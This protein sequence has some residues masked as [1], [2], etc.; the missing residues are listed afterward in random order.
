[1]GAR[2]LVW[3]PLAGR[4]WLVRAIKKCQIWARPQVASPGRALATGA[5]LPGSAPPILV[6]CARLGIGAPVGAPMP[7]PLYWNARGQTFANGAPK[8]SQRIVL[9][10][11]GPPQQ[12]AD[13]LLRGPKG[14]PKTRGSGGNGARRSAKFAAARAPTG[15]WAQITV[16][17]RQLA[18]LGLTGARDGPLKQLGTSGA[19]PLAHC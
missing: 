14:A 3:D 18:W 6:Q 15:G 4:Q 19:Q 11:G 9:D 7:L 5:R 1:M 17:A 8:W 10:A 12:R 2:V 16:Q 13:H